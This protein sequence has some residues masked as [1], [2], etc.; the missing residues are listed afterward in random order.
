MKTLLVLAPHP[1]LADAI[2]SGLSPE[3]YRIIHRASA[4]EAEPLLVHGLADVCVLDLELSGVQGVWMIEKLR[5]RAPRCP[6]IV[7]TGARQAEWEEEAY[8][9]GVKHVLSKPV[10]A[11]LLNTVLEGIFST[12]ASLPPAAPA[13]PADT[14]F[15]TPPEAPRNIM[16]NSAPA[17]GLATYQSL[18]ILR[19]FSAVLTHSLKADALLKQFLLLIREITGVNRAAIFLRPSTSSFMTSGGGAEGYQLTAACTIGLPAE[20]L[21][22]V[23]LSLESG[24]GSHVKR[25]GRILRRN[26]QEVSDIESQREFELLGAQVAIP[27]LDRESV[28]GVAVF[29]TRVTGEPLVN[30]E[31]ELIFHLLEQVGLAVKNIWL[32]D[33]VVGN[34]E[35]LADVMRELSSA[36]VVVGRDLTVVHANKTAR[37]FFG[38][39][40]ARAGELEFTDLPPALGS[41]VFQVLKTGSA[42]SPFRY[43]PEDVPGAVYQVTIVPIHHADATVPSSVLL[44]V[45]DRTQSEQLKQLEMEAKNLRL[46]RGMAERLAAEI[47][48]AM[49]PISVHQQLISERFKDAEFRAALDKALAEGVKRVDR[50]VHQMRYLAGNVAVAGDSISLGSLI[51]EAYQEAKKY[52]PGKPAKLNND[53]RDRPVVVAGDRAA[54]KHAFSEIILNALQSNPA[55]PQVAVRLRDEAFT[56][57]EVSIEVEDNGPGFTPEAQKEAT[58]PFFTT[59]IP[60]VGL[61]LAVTRKIIETHHGKLEIP[62]PQPG[63]PGVVRV[64]LP[65]ET[66]SAKQ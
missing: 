22:N 11:R 32:H 53:F 20:L 41:K 12:T 52:Q 36:C 13:R 10:R 59:R 34:H 6:I 15:F 39:T 5:R 23:R 64:S 51:E 42:V 40:G 3:Q 19:D 17:T 61:G 26:S 24:I 27:I 14:S 62:T 43:S 56:G 47:G 65:L 63:H 16:A 54:L 66:P 7:Y 46:I 45:E 1:E 58:T 25:L 44:M 49:V 29:D 57:H 4:E 38:Q 30:T 28:L 8:M 18:E 21:S 35:M 2:R 9:Q 48:N 55:S 37:K 31:L 50:L 33:Q 60:G